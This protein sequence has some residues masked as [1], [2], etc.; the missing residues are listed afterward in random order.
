MFTFLLC[1]TDMRLQN[2]CKRSKAKCCLGVCPEARRIHN[3]MYR[4]GDMALCRTYPYRYVLHGWNGSGAIPALC[5]AYPYRHVLH[6]LNGT[7]AIPAVQILRSNPA[8]H[9]PQDLNSFF[10]TCM[11]SEASAHAEFSVFCTHTHAQHSEARSLLR[12][13]FVEP[14]FIHA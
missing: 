4:E 8:V 5:R 3:C 9:I 2:F 7:G 6:G 14:L 13:G 10:N 11:H 1:E 12:R